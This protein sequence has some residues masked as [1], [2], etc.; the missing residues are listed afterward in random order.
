MSAK[1]FIKKVGT[2]GLGHS[3]TFFVSHWFDYL[4]YIPMVTFLGPVKG[5]GIMLVLSMIMNLT[6]IW[7][8]DKTGKDWLGF[9]AL[10][11]GKEEVSSKLPKWLKKAVTAGDTVAFIGLSVYDPLFAVIYLRKQDQV[12][13]GLSARDWKIFLASTVI[14]NIG[15]TG[16]IYGGVILFHIIKAAF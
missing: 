5:G 1:E 8:Y 4:L 12:F 3:V 11:Q 10:K 16:L 13:K 15:W 2:V 6:L 9:E 14:A 7:V